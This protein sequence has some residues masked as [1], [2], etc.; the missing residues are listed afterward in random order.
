MR[1]RIARRFLGIKKPV[2]IA[3]PETFVIYTETIIYGNALWRILEKDGIEQNCFENEVEKAR[4]ESHTRRGSYFPSDF[5]RYPAP[6]RANFSLFLIRGEFIC[7]E[8]INEMPSVFAHVKDIEGI[9]EIGRRITNDSFRLQSRASFAPTTLT[10][11]QTT[12]NRLLHSGQ[13]RAGVTMML[14]KRETRSSAGE[15]IRINYTSNCRVYNLI[16]FVHRKF[17]SN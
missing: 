16:A 11:W 17:A 14:V 10:H 2:A 4:I 1:I 6:H 12:G 9:T 15:R 7:D 3:N 8:S 5:H 13:T